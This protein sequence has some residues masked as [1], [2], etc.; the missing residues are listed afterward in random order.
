MSTTPMMHSTQPMVLCEKHMGIRTRYLATNG[1]AHVYFHEPTE[2]YVVSP[3]ALSSRQV[4][5]TVCDHNNQRALVML[6]D[7]ESPETIWNTL[8]ISGATI[9]RLAREEGIKLRHGWFAKAWAKSQANK[10]KGN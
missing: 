10:A 1:G 7:G 8:Y 9:G 4:E 2:S 6:R 3:K 5:R